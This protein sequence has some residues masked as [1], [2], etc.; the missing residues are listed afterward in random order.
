M[1][2]KKE[3]LKSKPECKVT[4]RLPKEIVAEA[5]TVNL[6]GDFNNWDVSSTPMKK[7]KTGEFTVTVSLKKDNEYQYRYL[8]DGKTWK[9]DEDADKYV[10][11]EFSGENAV[12]IV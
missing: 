7:L 10:M 11:N 1:M 4:F 3:Y 6:V 5:E 2:N 12:V 9:N 8:I